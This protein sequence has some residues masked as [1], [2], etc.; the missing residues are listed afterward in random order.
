MRTGTCG[1]CAYYYAERPEADPAKACHRYPPQVF[2]HIT[3]EAGLG[4]AD[5]V[6]VRQFVAFPRP[7]EHWS[8]GEHQLV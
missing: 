3:P 5:A 6:R 2:L 1:D 7:E 4:E 8:C